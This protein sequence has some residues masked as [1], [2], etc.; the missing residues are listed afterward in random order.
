MRRMNGARDA[1]VKAA[2]SI[3]A[4][5]RTNLSAAGLGCRVEVL[6]SG[7]CVGGS[8]CQLYR[9]GTVGLDAGKT[10]TPAVLLAVCA[11]GILV[12]YWRSFEHKIKFTRF[13]HFPP[14]PCVPLSCQKSLPA[15]P[16][17]PSRKLM[18]DCAH[19]AWHQI[20]QLFLQGVGTLGSLHTM[21]L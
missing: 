9:H 20:E 7:G 19:Q 13:Q 15:S 12:L 3:I 17:P 18:V 6:Q 2:R 1:P 4:S 10:V 16:T 14:T 11:V 8:S 5:A 21:A